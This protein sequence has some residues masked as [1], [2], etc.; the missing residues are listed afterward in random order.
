MKQNINPLVDITQRIS[1][2]DSLQYYDPERKVLVYPLA[3]GKIWTQTISPFTL[4]RTVL[5]KTIVGTPAG[6]FNCF[7]I[8][9]E[10]EEFPNSTYRG[11]YKYRCCD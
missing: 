10:I 8:K 1:F 11:F 9:T 5:A 3:V 6:S 7:K 2:E 4:K